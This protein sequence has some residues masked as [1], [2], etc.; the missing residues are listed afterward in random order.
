MFLDQQHYHRQLRQHV[1]TGLLSAERL[2]FYLHTD[3][4]R[5]E[6]VLFTNQDSDGRGKPYYIS[7]NSVST[8]LLVNA[9]VSLLSEF[10]QRNGRGR[11]EPAV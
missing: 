10:D 9:E 1:H 6:L 7:S 5:Q 11:G 4:V 3:A 8:Q 2:V